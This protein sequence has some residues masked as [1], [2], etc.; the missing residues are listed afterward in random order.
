MIIGTEG[1]LAEETANRG[2]FCVAND[3]ELKLRRN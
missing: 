2:V 1:R 3:V